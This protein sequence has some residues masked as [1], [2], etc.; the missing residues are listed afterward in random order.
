MRLCLL[1]CFILILSTPNAVLALTST[2]AAQLNQAQQAI[3]NQQAASAIG[4]L[5]QLIQ[6]H[7]D[8][9]QAHR[10][11]GHAYALTGQSDLA[12]KHLVIAITHGQMTSDSLARLYQLDQAQNNHLA[13]LVQL[14]L[15]TTLEP[16]NT[17]YPML[18]AQT[19]ESLS[20]TQAAQVIYQDQLQKQP[21]NPH[22]MLKLGHLASQS[23][24]YDKAIIYLQ[25]ADSL[26]QTTQSVKQT[27][28]WLYEQIK[29]PAQALQWHM[30]AWPIL[31]DAPAE[32][33]LQRVRLLW[34]IDDLSSAQQ[35]AED[36]IEQNKHADQ[37]LMLLAKIAI[38]SEQPKLAQ[39]CFEQLAA[40]GKAPAN[41]TAYLG[42]IAFNDANYVQAAHYLT[43]SDKQQPLTQDQL[44]SLII[45][46]LKSNNPMQARIAIQSYI[47]R[48]EL[49]DNVHQ[50]IKLWTRQNDHQGTT[51]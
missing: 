28:S 36:M 23:S 9:A 5:T 49:D 51:F 25:T 43:I 40:M 37:A 41:I 17:Q 7:P 12:R 42:S 21:A 50:S 10:L 38:Q 24:A 8:L 39:S 34:Q 29:L 20:D 32:Q 4:P 27:L 18:L 46:H 26:G 30:Q 16:D 45:S 48:F 2:E 31:K 19:Y 11:L 6:N 15:L 3:N 35:V 13:N 44:H 1:S 14:L 33:Q 47:I 22:L